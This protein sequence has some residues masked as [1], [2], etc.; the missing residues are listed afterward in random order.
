MKKTNSTALPPRRRI[1]YPV[2]A[3]LIV[4]ALL[5]GGCAMM[6]PKNQAF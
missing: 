1:L 4:M 2:V 6:R 3:S 5:L